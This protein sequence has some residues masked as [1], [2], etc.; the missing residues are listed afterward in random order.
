MVAVGGQ[1]AAGRIIQDF[2][3]WQARRGRARGK[4]SWRSARVRFDPPAH[5]IRKCIACDL[6]ERFVHACLN[7]VLYAR[8]RSSGPATCG[9]IVDG[10][11][12]SLAR[13]AAIIAGQCCSDQRH[14]HQLRA[15]LGHF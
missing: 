15:Q 1:V 3:A 9:A 12:T 8:T 10:S 11:P 4:W 2:I 13:I 6:C 5:V 7:H 14:A